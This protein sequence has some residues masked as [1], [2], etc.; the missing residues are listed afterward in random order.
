MVK[1]FMN[2]CI[3]I[4]MW[5]L[6]GY[7]FAFGINDNKIIGLDHFVGSGFRKSKHLSEFSNIF[8]LKVI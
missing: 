6:V 1:V 2:T 7:A 3:A 4:L 5:W 8:I